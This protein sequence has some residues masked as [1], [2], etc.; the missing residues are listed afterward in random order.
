MPSASSYGSSAEGSWP[1]SEYPDPAAETE[2][3]G[4]RERVA[5]VAGRVGEGVS[6]AVGGCARARLGA[7]AAAGDGSRRLR[8]RARATTVRGPAALSAIGPAPRVAARPG[9]ATTCAMASTP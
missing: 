2:E 4:L 3:G 5:D 8:I 1:R 9:R 7:V 6:E